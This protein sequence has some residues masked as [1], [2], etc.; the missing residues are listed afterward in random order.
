V[1]LLRDWFNRAQSV[2]MADVPTKLDRT[3]YDN[4]WARSVADTRTRLADPRQDAKWLRRVA[5]CLPRE[6]ITGRPR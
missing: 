4:A 6:L 1:N 5:F 3:S 2:N